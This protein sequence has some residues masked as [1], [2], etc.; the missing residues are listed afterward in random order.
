[1]FLALISYD[2]VFNH[3]TEWCI[4]FAI[5]CSVITDLFSTLHD[6]AINWNNHRGVSSYFSCPLIA[7]DVYRCGYACVFQCNGD[8]FEQCSSLALEPPVEEVGSSFL[9]YLFFN[10]KVV[11]DVALLEDCLL[12]WTDTYLNWVNPK[13]GVVDCFLYYAINFD[14]YSWCYSSRCPSLMVTIVWSDMKQDVHVQGPGDVSLIHSRVTRCYKAL[15]DYDACECISPITNWSMQVHDV[16]WPIYGLQAKRYFCEPLLLQYEVAGGIYPTSLKIL[17]NVDAYALSLIMIVL[18]E[19]RTTVDVS[20]TFT[21]KGKIHVSHSDGESQQCSNYVAYYRSLFCSLWLRDDI[22]MMML[23]QARCVNANYNDLAYDDVYNYALMYWWLWIQPQDVSKLTLFALLKPSSGNAKLHLSDAVSMRQ[24]SFTSFSDEMGRILERI[25]K[26][27]VCLSTDFKMTFMRSQYVKRLL[28]MILFITQTMDVVSHMVR[29][30]GPTNTLNMFPAF[31]AR[32]FGLLYDYSYFTLLYDEFLKS[33]VSEFAQTSM[34]T[35]GILQAAARK[36][37]TLMLACC[38]LLLYAP[39]R[40]LP[41]DFMAYNMWCFISKVIFQTPVGP[42]TSVISQHD[43]STV[44]EV[45]YAVSL[46]FMKK[47][48]MVHIKFVNHVNLQFSMANF[49]VSYCKAIF[50]AIALYFKPSGVFNML[51]QC[52]SQARRGVMALHVFQ[53]S[54]VTYFSQESSQCVP[55]RK[56]EPVIFLLN[57]NWW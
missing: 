10:D 52:R 43:D 28:P 40:F 39:G 26:S 41:A 45:T 49:P 13:G 6:G 9:L 4:S 24:R 27:V 48:H 30:T 46:S 8:G 17:V 54:L 1:M 55:S 22:I 23:V 15:T 36:V 25:E 34:I 33:I 21:R 2:R 12:I 3:D 44:P 38:R 56:L 37:P 19:G 29:T 47:V 5:N 16:S 35:S 20:L 14:A 31:T 32:L 50:R 57:T 18:E 51:D 7:H 53:C 11:G 42:K